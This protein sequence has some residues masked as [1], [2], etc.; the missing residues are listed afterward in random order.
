MK[1][2]PFVICLVLSIQVA[3]AEGPPT[4]NLMPVPAQ[5]ELGDASI[6][7]GPE[8]SV[9]IEGEGGTPRLHGGVGRMLRRL[10]D[11]SALFFDNSTFLQLKG[12]SMAAMVVTAGRAGELALGEDESY[13][14]T[15]TSDGIA[16]Q[17]ATDIG[18]LRGLETFLQLLTLDENGVTVPEI[19]IFDQP[20]FPWRG[21]MIDSSRHFMP[22]EMV[23]RNLD[24]MAAVKLN[25]LHWHLVDD[26]GFRVETLAWPKLHELASDGNYYTRAQIRDIIDYAAE[27]GIRVVPEFDLPGHGSAWL[28]AYPELASA[29]GPYEI[30]RS[31]GIFDPTIN[32]TI[33]KTYEFLDALMAEMAELFDDEFIHI[34][35][36]ENNGKHWLA[37]PEIVAFM[38]EKGYEGPLTLQRYFNERVLAILTKYGKRM[39]GWDE[40]F[41][42]GLPK[43]V[44]IQSWRGRESLFE[45]A[46]LGYSGILSNGYYI[47]LIHPTDDHYLNDPLPADSP[48]TPEEAARI[49]GGEATMWAEYVSPETVDSRIWPRTA[50]IAERFW[51]PSRVRDLEDMYRRMDRIS[52][53]LEELGLQ[54]ERNRPMMLR[55]LC[56]CRDVAALEVLLGAIEPVKVYNRGR[57]RKHTQF[58]PLTRMADAAW[59]DAGPA[60]DFRWAVERL[61]ESDFMDEEDLGAVESTLIAWRDNRG[62]LEE[63]LRTSPAL[64]DIEPMS[65]ALAEASAIGLEALVLATTDSSANKDWLDLRLER[66]NAA[67]KSHGQVE[68]VMI[69]PVVDLVCAVTLPVSMTAEGCREQETPV[70]EHH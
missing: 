36:D 51:S 26:Q 3:A 5:L 2:V 45:S 59:P 63:T 18:A 30:E 33:E 37:N 67:R 25:V 65:S 22:V 1:N 47:D 61:I 69:D 39:I 54:H 62:A 24:G 48:L 46:R 50:A 32:P 57:L 27:R 34:G 17:A 4:L 55:R 43:N 8:F 58:S 7:I 64:A 53:M 42:E 13:R 16:L 20:R 52:L 31:W 66:L 28:T 56:Q 15:I 44:V 21:L 11:R 19:A 40:I 38:D 10:S 14:L 49:L 9:T 35:G 29:P 23:K 6:K 41:E 12:R 60:R 68:L 70:V